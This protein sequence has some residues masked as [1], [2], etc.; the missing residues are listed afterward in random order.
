M[1]RGASI[2]TVWNRVVALAALGCMIGVTAS[3]A[4]PR[5]VV[6]NDGPELGET[7]TITRLDHPLAAGSYVLYASPDAP[8]PGA[9]VRAEVFVDEG[10]TYLA[11]IFPGVHRGKATYRVVSSGTKTGPSVG[12]QTEGRDVRIVLEREPFTTYR[13]DTGP[14]P[15]LFPLIGPTGT[16]Y[17]RSFPMETV[18][19]EDVDHPHQKSFWFTYGSVNGIDFWAELPGHGSIRETSRPVSH[20]GDV[21]GVLKTTDDWLG[22]DGKKQLEDSR[23]LHVFNAETARILDYDVTLTASDG[24][25][26]FGDTKE[27]MFGVRVATSMDVKKG[28]PGG[29]IVNAEGLIDAATWGKKSPWVDYSGPVR[30]QTVGIAILDH[31]G[32]FGYPTPW[33][34]REYGLFAANPF[35]KHEFGL[36]PKA[37]PTV[38]EAGKSL[39]FRYRVILHA[40]DA[41]AYP[42]GKA[43]EAFARP[44]KIEIE[45]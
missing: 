4:E 18:P 33:H 45:K 24:P 35:G 32:N 14:K 17:T 20:G 42:V 8:P 16:K 3:A 25:V 36:S 44:P 34:V 5:L 28:K 38:M 26:T 19:G 10:I 2:M 31:P 1:H 23:V 12:F 37:E 29:K 41:A 13:P 22:P 15:I 11:A 40:G 39:H 9:S 21:V 7:P 6:T 27:G 43:F 30:S